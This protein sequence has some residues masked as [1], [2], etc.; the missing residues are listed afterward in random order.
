MNTTYGLSFSKLLQEIMRDNVRY[1]SGGIRK[2]DD[3]LNP[4]NLSKL[5]DRHNGIFCFLAFHPKTDA[6]VGEYIENGSLA[7]DAGKEILVL[8]VVN[9]LM[10][11]PSPIIKEKLD[12][13][14]IDEEI[15]PAYDAIK[16]LFPSSNVSLPGIVFFDSFSEPKDTIYVPL[17]EA[18][19]VEDVSTS[20]RKIFS[21]A[22]NSFNFNSM[23]NFGDNF[24]YNLK[25]K[26]CTYER[27][28]RISSREW[29]L[30]LYKS[31]YKHRA[32]IV[33]VFSTAK[34]AL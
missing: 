22:R 32:D 10:S 1:A 23:E 24:A 26:N 21:I 13:I 12:F 18:V 11:S 19:T 14:E 7:S 9:S 31:I 20:C 8:F 2:L 17:T 4:G 15:H 3:L 6:I 34:S 29:L 5:Q 30:G 33:S 28:Q 25:I 16:Y 27:S